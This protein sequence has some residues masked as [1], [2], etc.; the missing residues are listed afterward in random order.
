[1]AHKQMESRRHEGCKGGEERGKWL[2]GQSGEVTM[3]LPF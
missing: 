2:V 1:M 3:R